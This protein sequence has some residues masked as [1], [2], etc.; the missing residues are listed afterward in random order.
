MRRPKLYNS[1]L[2][3]QNLIRKSSDQD[4]IR[5][6]RSINIYVDYLERH[7]DKEDIDVTL[8]DEGD[9]DADFD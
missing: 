1:E 5:Y 7:I 8:D 3:L 2:L 9:T 4:L 6:I